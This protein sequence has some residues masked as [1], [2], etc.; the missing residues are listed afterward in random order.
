MRS[1][2]LGLYS[3]KRLDTQISLIIDWSE[4]D[5]LGDHLFI[6][7]GC[8]IRITMVTSDFLVLFGYSALVDRW[9]RVLIRYFLRQVVWH[10]HNLRSS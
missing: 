3:P 4:G 5:D 9:R 6:D 1:F 7:R 2:I 8:V 10:G